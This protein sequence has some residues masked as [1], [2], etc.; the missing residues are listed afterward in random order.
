MSEPTLYRCPNCN[1]DHHISQGQEPVCPA[2][3]NMVP[4]EL[5]LDNEAAAKCLWYQERYTDFRDAMTEEQSE[6]RRRARFV[7]DAAL[8][9]GGS[10]E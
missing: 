5:K 9:I 7:V 2:C 4:V 6:Y 1:G 10:D 8:G 3:V